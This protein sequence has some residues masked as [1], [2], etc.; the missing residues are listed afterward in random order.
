MAKPIIADEP[1][2]FGRTGAGANPAALD[3]RQRQDPR[4]P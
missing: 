3:R 2:V 1:A 4:A